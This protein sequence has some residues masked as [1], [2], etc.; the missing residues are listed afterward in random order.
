MQNKKRNARKTLKN[1]GKILKTE[2]MRNVVALK[3]KVF[4]NK[5]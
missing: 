2:N 5:L 1:F 4:S 3:L